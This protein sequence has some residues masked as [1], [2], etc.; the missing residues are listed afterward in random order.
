NLQ[1]HYGSAEGGG[2]QF[3]TAASFG[4]ARDAVKAAF[5]MD[6]STTQ[7]LLGGERSLWA[8]QDYRR[9]GSVDQRST[10]SSPGNVTSILPGNLPGLSSPIAAIPGS[11]AGEHTALSEFLPGQ[12]NLESLLQ[13]VPI[14]PDT[15]RASVVA[16]AQV[17]LWPTDVVASAE[18]MYVDRTV[19]FPTMSPLVPLAVV[20]LTNPFNPFHA[21]VLVSTRLV[22]LGRQE[23]DVDS[24]LTRGVVSLRGKAAA[25][26]WEFSLLRSEEDAQVR[27]ENTIDFLKLQQ[28]LA[29][30]DPSQTL[31]LFRPGPAASQ[32]I[33]DSLLA[34]DVVNHYAT[35]ATQLGGL[36]SGRVL[37]LP[38]GLLTAM[39]G[40]EW[41]KES[42]RF[43]ADHNAFEREV[44]A[45]YAELT[46]PIVGADMHVPAI[47]ELKLT[48]GGRL[49]RYSDFGEIFNPQFGL[50]WLP[51]QDLAFRVSYGHSFRAPSMYELY[52]P[53]L[54]SQPVFPVADPRRGGAP[55][56]VSLVTGGNAELE[57][58]IGKALNAGIVF[59]PAAL[60]P[61]Q[62]FASYWHVVMDN[63]ITLLQP[64]L[65]L[66]N[67]NLFPQRVVRAEPTAVDVA[68]GLPGSVT[69]ID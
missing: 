20:P 3:Q 29:N 67:E 68:A 57:P 58:T 63:R 44:D 23:Q 1:M 22:G 26:D 4:Y 15:S 54:E 17:E 52:L 18:L 10:S 56:T 13:Y 27:L 64:T 9:F 16:N 65:V 55:S 33:L 69:Q 2:S 66:A 12:R 7:T 35:D 6:Y 51:Y 41:R 61:I 30:P 28:V 19:R 46:V 31:D 39:F 24:T 45:A 59:T 25:W 43:E 14:V 32:E 47:R 42:V 37:E 5:I 36:A 8:D 60:P 38:G 49:D 50:R 21:P 62:V 11:I 34:P 53:R 48:A 40:G